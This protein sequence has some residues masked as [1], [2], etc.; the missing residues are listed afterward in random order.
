[1][2]S[3]DD[4]VGAGGGCDRDGWKWGIESDVNLRTGNANN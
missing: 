2:A 1:M 4:D 3:A